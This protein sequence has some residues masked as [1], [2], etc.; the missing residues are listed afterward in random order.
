MITIDEAIKILSECQLTLLSDGAFGDAETTW[1]K[2]GIE[3]A[4]GY[5]SNSKSE[6]QFLIPLTVFDKSQR[7]TF[8]GDEA[9]RLKNVGKLVSFS[10]N[11]SLE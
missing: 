9:W 1:H 8:T 11:D 3:V 2:D 5:F 4:W 7:A 6:V 10:R